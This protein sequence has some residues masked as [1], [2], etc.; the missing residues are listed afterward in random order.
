MSSTMEVD[1]PK[2]G[3]IKKV[4]VHPVRAAFLGGVGGCSFNGRQ[5]WLLFVVFVRG[6]EFLTQSLLPPAMIVIHS[7]S[8]AVA[9]CVYK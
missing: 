6:N 7:F 1:S 8:C 5:V 2:D 3:E 4:S 9:V